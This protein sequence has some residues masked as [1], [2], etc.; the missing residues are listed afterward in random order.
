MTVPCPHC[1]NRQPVYA[2]H[3]VVHCDMFT[4]ECVKCESTFNSLC[5][6]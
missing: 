5:I 2:P 6:C 1:G 4:L 3:W